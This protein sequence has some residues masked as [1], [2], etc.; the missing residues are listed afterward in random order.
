[1]KDA[2]KQCCS[3]I[4]ALCAVFSWCSLGVGCAGLNLLAESQGFGTD[5][6]GSEERMQAEACRV[7]GEQLALAERDEQAIVQLERARQLNP[8]IRGTAHT[9]AVLY[10]RQ[11]LLDAAE[12]EYRA[13]LRESPRDADVLN[14]YG[15]FLYSRGDNAGSESHLREALRI[16][17]GHPQA[18]LNLALTLAGQGRY[19]ESFAEFERALGKASGHYNV[20]V[21]L[22]RSGEVERGMEQLRLSLQEDPGLEAARSLLEAP[23]VQGMTVESAVVAQGEG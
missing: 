16:Q 5:R 14:D 23:V 10:D 12:R 8:Q 13:A 1:M 11:R 15:Y 7:T 21:L 4:G 6:V 2:R 3:R 17:A 9:L 20:A 18:R 19:E 22:L